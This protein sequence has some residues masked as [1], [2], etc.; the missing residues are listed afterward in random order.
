MPPPASLT[1]NQKQIP[2]SE[3]TIRSPMDLGGLKS[4]A[5]LEMNPQGKMPL[6]STPDFAL[7]ESDTI[8]RFLLTEYPGEPSFLPDAARSNLIAR[9][10]DMY[11]TT[12]QGCLYKA[13]PPFGTFGTRKAAIEEFRKQLGILDDLVQGGNYLLGEEVSLADATLFPTAV[14]AQAMLPKFGVPSDEALPPKLRQWFQSVQR[15]DPVFAR[16]HEE[17]SPPRPTPP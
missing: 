2:E 10:H 3:V 14:F 7:P 11:L 5:Y 4:P 13:T 17:V 6:L 12:I 16:V 15:A 1:R 9:I 8:C